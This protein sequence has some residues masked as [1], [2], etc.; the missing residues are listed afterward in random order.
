MFP[1]YDV[2]ADYQLPG[3]SAPGR[4]HTHANRCRQFVGMEEGFCMHRKR[5]ELKRLK[6]RLWRFISLLSQILIFII[7][8]FS[9]SKVEDI[10]LEQ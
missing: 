8:G 7:S 4:L 10:H 9:G 6:F 2:V 1:K 5:S 3:A